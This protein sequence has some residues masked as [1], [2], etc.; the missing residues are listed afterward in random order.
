MAC[1]EEM[2]AVWLEHEYLTDV[3][4]SWLTTRRF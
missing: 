3:L 2:S 1:A 4:I